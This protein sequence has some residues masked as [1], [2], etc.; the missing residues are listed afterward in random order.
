MPS[1]PSPPTYEND[2]KEFLTWNANQA[3]EGYTIANMMTR[4]EFF[5]G[6]VTRTL[7]GFRDQISHL[8]GR[9][10]DLESDNEN[11]HSRLDHHGAAIIAIKRRVRLGPQ[12]QEMDTGVHELAAIQQRLAEQ[13]KKRSESERVKAE[14]V[15]WWKRTIIQAAFGALAFIAT[16]V[17]TVLV[18]LAL[19]KSS[20]QPVST[21][22]SNPPSQSPPH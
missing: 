13:E 22:V 3:R 20:F 9:T 12:D 19:T 8:N 5:F 6:E 17:F 7:N 1:P 15:V 14:D 4:Q 16:T 18:T 21:P 10:S 2:V 11:I